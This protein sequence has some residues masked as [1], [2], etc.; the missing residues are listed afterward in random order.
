MNFEWDP[1]KA[2]ENLRRHGVS[3]DEAISVFGDPLAQTLAD[4]YHSE[5]EARELTL[6]V[7]RQGRAIVV[8]HCERGRRTRIIRII[9][10][11]E[12]TRRE[13]RDPEEGTP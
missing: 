8:A 1:G 3:F 12:M 7:S 4:P 9:S 6:G 11:R 5:S 2:A 10:A 13:K